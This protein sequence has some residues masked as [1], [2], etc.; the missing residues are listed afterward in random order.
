MHKAPSRDPSC[1][2]ERLIPPRNAIPVL[3]AAGR[4]LVHVSGAW[5]GCQPDWPAGTLDCCRPVRQA[6][7]FQGLKLARGAHRKQRCV[8][9]P[10][11]AVASASSRPGLCEQGRGDCGQDPLVL[12][13]SRP[14]HE[15]CALFLC[16]QKRPPR[17][18]AL[19]ADECRRGR[20][21]LFPRRPAGDSPRPDLS[22]GKTVADAVQQRPS[23]EGLQ[24]GWS[25]S[26]PNHELLQA[27]I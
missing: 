10:A 24:E 4:G 12:R 2:R 6:T 13:T 8:R 17:K 15:T 20:E 3:C 22:N 5:A 9:E 11:H 19:R 1:R 7:C 23:E 18:G 25:R 14:W 27:C 26:L 21:Q 16:P